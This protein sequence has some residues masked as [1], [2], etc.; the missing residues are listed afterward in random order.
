[1]ILLVNDVKFKNTKFY[2]AV[3]FIWLKKTQPIFN[4]QQIRE[5]LYSTLRMCN[6]SFVWPLFSSCW[7]NCLLKMGSLVIHLCAGRQSPCADSNK[8]WRSIMCEEKQ[9]CLAAAHRPCSP[10]PFLFQCGNS[11][12]MTSLQALYIM[13]GRWETSWLL[14]FQPAEFCSLTECDDC[15]LVFDGKERCAKVWII[16]VV[17]SKNSIKK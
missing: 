8:L 9:S 3:A 5:S 15:I 7:S 6:P 16:K 17:W 11:W 10:P 1:M 2:I 13:V 12:K 14:M 4:W